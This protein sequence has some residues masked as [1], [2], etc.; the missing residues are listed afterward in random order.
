MAVFGNQR[1]FTMRLWVHGV[2]NKRKKAEN[3]TI[4]L[5]SL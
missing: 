3:S 2:Y 4:T 5:I 1:S